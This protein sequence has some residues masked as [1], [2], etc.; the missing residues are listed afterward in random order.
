[1]TDKSVD[2]NSWGSVGVAPLPESLRL[3]W[4]AEPLPDWV[5]ADF[6]LP[7]GSSTFSALDQSVWSV[8]SATRLTD[9]QRNFLRNLLQTR[10]AGISSLSVFTHPLPYWLN[11]KELPFSTRTRNCLVSSN[12]IAD[13]EQLSKV[14]FARLFEVRAMGVGCILELAC[15]VEAAI[16]R[17]SKAQEASFDVSQVM[18]LVSEPWVD[19][20]GSADPRFADLIPPLR[21][22]TVFELLDA[23]TSA[24]ELDEQSLATLAQSLPELRKRLR[25]IKALP[26]EQQLGDFIRRVTRFEGERLSALIDRLGWAG[27]PPIT[28]EQAGQRLGVTRERFRQIQERA[29]ERFKDIAFPP[30]LP[31]LD[32]ALAILREKCPIS[33]S[34]ATEFLKQNSITEID[35][36]PESL[37]IAAEACHRKPSIFLQTVGSRTIVAATE[38]SNAD[39]ILR[40]A[41]RQTQASGAS[42]VGELTAELRSRRVATDEKAVGHVL[43]EF[44]DVQF[45]EGNWFGRRPDNPER[46]RLR[47][48][49]RKMLSVASPI[50]LMTL[51]E[52]IRREYRYRG[53]RGGKTWSLIVPPRSILRSYYQVHPEFLSDENDM[54][55][56]A[57]PL[58]Y[59]TELA[60]NEAIFVDALRSSPTC[61]LDRQSLATECAR[62]SMNVNTF[63]IYLTYSPVIA[64]LGTDIWSLRGVRVDPAAVEAVRSA[65]AMRPREKRIL[66]HGWSDDGQLWVAARLRAAHLGTPVFGI[67]GPICNY[68][69]GRQFIAKDED[70]VT[71]GTIKI[72]DEGSSYGFGPFL[73]QRGA[74]EGDILIAEFNLA[75]DA[76]MLRLGND[77]LLEE[78]SPEV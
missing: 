65:N 46:D 78:M 7:K 2:S 1:V 42:N 44:S 68:L 38:I 50:D 58:D 63:A 60:L 4:A 64:H 5:A 76:A 70:G 52:G 54:V 27:S 66:D 57:T 23:L 33:I 75:G 28:L 11:V 67:P 32:S 43:R 74:D 45:F 20:I 24:P 22:G 36:H 17:A 14:S 16:E 71:H 29:T 48:V 73:R 10:R 41:L 25:L 55:S 56:P 72:N 12:L 9:R 62:R 21:Y 69:A 47:N 61:V 39:E 51:R 26:L 13:S 30:Y 6:G 40:I 3:A 53:H 19:Q 49:T 77:E 35:F 34:A 15:V 8:S 37:I 31:G 18:E 59:R